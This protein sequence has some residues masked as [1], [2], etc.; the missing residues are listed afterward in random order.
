MMNLDNTRLQ[1]IQAFKTAYYDL[2][3]K[4]DSI[5]ECV[6]LQ[7]HIDELEKEENEI[8]SRSGVEI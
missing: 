1:E 2:L 8:L 5:S 7:A 3:N 4:S 6:Q